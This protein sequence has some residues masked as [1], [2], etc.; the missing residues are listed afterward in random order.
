LLTTN[1]LLLILQSAKIYSVLRVQN[2]ASGFSAQRSNL[3]PLLDLIIPILGFLAVITRKRE[4]TGVLILYSSLQFTRMLTIFP[5]IGKNIFITIQVTR[6]I[7]ELLLSYIVALFAFAITFHILLDEAPFDNLGDSFIKMVMMLLGEVEFGDLKDVSWLTKLI[8]LVFVILMSIVLINLVIGLSISD[9]VSLRKD[10]H[11]HKVINTVSAIRSV[12]NLKENLSRICRRGNQL[13]TKTCNYKVWL[14]ISDLDYCSA[15]FLHVVRNLEEKD[16]LVPCPGTI[17]RAIA[18]ILI[19]RRERDLAGC[20]HSLER[21][22]LLQRVAHLEEE[23][24]SD[25]ISTLPSPASSARPSQLETG[26]RNT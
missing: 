18:R 23:M 9:V 8:F 10:A 15:N 16:E 22:H 12:H 6:T 19:D 7:L 26:S 1:I 14:E 21:R 2:K 4:I 17:L 20:I 5:R 25:L 11:I 3:Y 24:F 13:L